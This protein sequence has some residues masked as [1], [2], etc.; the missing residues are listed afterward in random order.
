MYNIDD[1]PEDDSENDI[2][3]NDTPGR[4]LSNDERNVNK[5]EFET[6]EKI[7]NDMRSTDI[8]VMTNQMKYMMKMIFCILV[9][10]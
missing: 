6:E 9:L 3:L 7:I 5:D 1:N 8:L 2:F 10:Q 4:Y